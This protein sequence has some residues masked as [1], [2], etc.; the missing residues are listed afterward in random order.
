MV[1]TNE[2]LQQAN[3]L[4]KLANALKLRI[5]DLNE[6]A[7]NNIISELNEIADVVEIEAS[8]QHDLGEDFMELENIME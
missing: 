3:R 1:N 8:K 6:L 5:K 2:L 4:R 7:A